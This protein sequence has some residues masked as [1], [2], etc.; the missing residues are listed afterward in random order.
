MPEPAIT[1]YAAE[2]SLFSGKARAYLRYKGIPFR[3]ELPTWRVVR[4]VLVPNTGLAMVPV[5]RTVDGRFVQDTSE[6]IDHFEASHPEPAVVPVTPRQHV[7]SH[8]LELYADEWLVLPAMRYRWRMGHLRYVARAFGGLS[9]P[10]APRWLHG[11]LGLPMAAYFGVGHVPV[12]GLGPRMRR[13][14]D[15]MYPAFLASF[16]AHLAVH[17]YVLGGRPTLADFGLYGPLYAHLYC[18]S[19]SHDEMKEQAPRVADWVRRMTD[20]SP[21]AMGAVL[22]DDE[23]PTTLEPLLRDLFRHQW[24]VVLDTWHRIDAYLSER[25]G[26]RRLPRFVGRHAFELEGVR[27]RRSVHTYTAWMSQRAMRAREALTPDDRAWLDRLG[28]ASFLAFR[29]SREL[30]RDHGRIVTPTEPPMVD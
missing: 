15:R 9:M 27:G 12:L 26:Q 7:V 28:G 6:I 11:L 3:E 17:P 13:A 5:V 8:L 23:V 16:E 25:P 4:E 19:R 10:D 2:V 29:P 24:P 22:A 14:V 1:L 21:D 20:P 18:D 30:L